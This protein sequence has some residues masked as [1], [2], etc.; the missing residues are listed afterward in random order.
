M[1]ITYEYEK[2][3]YNK[4]EK[5]N[6]V[7]GTLG[8][9]ITPIITAKYAID[10]INPNDNLSGEV[11]NWTFSLT[12]NC[13]P[14]LDSKFPIPIYTGIAGACVGKLEAERL[15]RNRLKQENNLENIF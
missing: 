7:I 11:F 14:M 2:I 4:R 13:L 15:K 10:I 12:L 9:I 5:M 6:I 1:T 8:G 3:P